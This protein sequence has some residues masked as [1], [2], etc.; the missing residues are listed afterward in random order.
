M[1][2]PILTSI[3][4]WHHLRLM[5]S[6]FERVPNM[7]MV[8][9]IRLHH[10]SIVENTHLITVKQMSRLL[11]RK[12]EMDLP[13]LIHT[14]AE[15]KGKLLI[16]CAAIYNSLFPSWIGIHFVWRVNTSNDMQNIRMQKYLHCS[17]YCMFI[18]V[19]NMLRIAL[20]SYPSCYADNLATMKVIL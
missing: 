16:L 15:G 13:S 6:L 4:E 17:A 9:L 12:V 7:Q 20:S 8:P 3:H 11:H 1:C 2:Y 19:V 18:D 14:D 10:I 5:M